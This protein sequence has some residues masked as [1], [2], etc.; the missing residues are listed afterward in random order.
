MLKHFHT[1]DHIKSALLLSRESFCTYFTV[2]NT[3]SL[4][5]K[6][7]KFSNFQCLACQIYSKHGCASACH[8]ICQNAATATYIKYA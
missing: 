4:G 6:R 8:R 2:L 1:S 5:L 3:L 7:M